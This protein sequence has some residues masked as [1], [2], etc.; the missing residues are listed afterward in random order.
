VLQ[1]PA[2]EEWIEAA[3]QE[4]SAASV[5]A[6]PAAAEPA[7][8]A[9]VIPV[10][11]AAEP[12]PAKVQP[13]AIPPPAARAVAAASAAAEDLDD[14]GEDEMPPGP[15]KRTPPVQ[16]KAR[17]A[18]KDVPPPAGDKLRSFILPPD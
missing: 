3:A 9:K 13:A 6:I 12:A 10:R 1:H 11:A 18:A 5:P 7:P 2:I 14:I 17:P 16:Q 15:A 4:R 8:K